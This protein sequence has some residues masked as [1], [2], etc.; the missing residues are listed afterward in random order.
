M[1]PGADVTEVP[2]KFQL[3]ACDIKGRALCLWPRASGGMARLFI[4]LR[5]RRAASVLCHIDMLGS[6]RI[7][8]QCLRGVWPAGLRRV[9]GPSP[10]SPPADAARV[11]CML[12]FARTS[13]PGR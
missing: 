10:H 8:P 2:W 11:A 7:F 4:R 12:V 5:I 6:G 3:A 13:R 1:A 9:L